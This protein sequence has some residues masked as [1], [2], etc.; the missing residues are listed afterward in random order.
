MSIPDVPQHDNGQATDNGRQRLWKDVTSS[1]PCPRCGKSSWCRVTEDGD[2]CSCRRVSEG[3]YKV[4]QD[5]NSEDYYLHRLTPW[6]ER[7]PLPEPTCQV[8]DGKG[9]I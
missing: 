3:A 1:S 7:S 6:P 9:E 5:N 8:E 4:A 2:L